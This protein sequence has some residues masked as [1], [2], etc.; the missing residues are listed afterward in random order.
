MSTFLVP[1]VK[2]RP[3]TIIPANAN[4]AIDPANG[5]NQNPVVNVSTS[6]GQNNANIQMNKINKRYVTMHQ[7]IAYLIF[8]ILAVVTADVIMLVL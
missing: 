1:K 7:V 8:F 3:A 4:N 2:N 6:I 5:I